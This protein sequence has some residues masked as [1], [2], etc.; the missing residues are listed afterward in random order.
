ME[1]YRGQSLSFHIY[2]VSNA[3]IIRLTEIQVSIGCSM[4]EN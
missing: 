3:Q 1:L 4:F 2:D